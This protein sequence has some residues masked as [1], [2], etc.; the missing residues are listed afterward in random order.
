[1][2]G[3]SGQPCP[4]EAAPPAPTA[5]PRRAPAPHA[6]PGALPG[7]LP[8]AGDPLAPHA[9][10]LQPPQALFPGADPQ[11]TP[12]ALGAG[13]LI[14]TEGAA[15]SDP[16][17]GD[18]GRLLENMLRALQLHHHPRAFVC[19]LAPGPGSDPQGPIP[20]AQAA[21]AAQAALSEA[22]GQLQPA[23]LLLLGRSVARAVLGRSDPLGR[24]RAERLQLAGVPTVVS[25][26]APYLLRAPP[27]TKAQVWADLCRARALAGGSAAAHGASAPPSA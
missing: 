15:G 13:W 3:A 27:Q 26:D 19:L 7:A 10:E 18:A 4:P 22:L 1:M 6:P 2:P 9:W 23:V 21:Q 12:A 16:L 20:G 25:H 24:L 11:R 5:A 14:V 8:G 17:A